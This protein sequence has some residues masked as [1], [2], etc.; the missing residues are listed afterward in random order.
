[1]AELGSTDGEQDLL[2]PPP[3]PQEVDQLRVPCYLDE[4]YAQSLRVNASAS[5]QADSAQLDAMLKPFQHMM[6]TSDVHPTQRF[7]TPGAPQD[8]TYYSKIALEELGTPYADGLSSENRAKIAELNYLDVVRGR[9]R[10]RRS[11]SNG[12]N[13]AR[14]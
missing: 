7:F 13:F 11:S 3:R 8:P 9:Q 4:G 6:E 14:Q 12:L 10:Q 2:G 1:M 5:N